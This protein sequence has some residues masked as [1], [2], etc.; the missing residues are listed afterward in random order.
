M[1]GFAGF[2]FKRRQLLHTHH[3]ILHQALMDFDTGK[4]LAV[5]S[6]DADRF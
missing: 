2:Y 5:N 6:Y 1:H 4:G 3:A